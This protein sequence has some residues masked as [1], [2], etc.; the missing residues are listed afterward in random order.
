MSRTQRHPARRAV[1]HEDPWLDDRRAHDG[2]VVSQRVRKRVEEIFGWMKTVGGFRKA[3]Y[4]GLG[5]NPTA[6]YMIAAAYNLLRIA[7]LWPDP[8]RM[9]GALT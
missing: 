2:Y 1:H 7:K 4:V 9:H 5:A 6:G 3:R 8:R